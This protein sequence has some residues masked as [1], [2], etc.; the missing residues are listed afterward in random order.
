MLI[1]SRALLGIAGATVAPSTLSLVTNLFRDPRQRATAFGVWLGC[2]TLGA[3]I[4]PVV[5]GAMLAHFW[6]GSVFLLGVPAMVLLLVLGPVLLPEYRAPAA[7]RLDLISAALLLATILP[8]VYGLKELARHGWQP[9]PVAAIV[10]GGAFAVVFVRRQH[11]LADPLLDLRLFANPAFSTVLGSMLTFSML[12]GGTMVF[13]AQHFQ[14]VDELSALQAG[15]ALLPGMVAGLISVQLGPLLARWVRPAYLIGAGVAVSVSG[16]LVIVMSGRGSGPVPLMIGLAIASLGGG[17]LLSLGTDLVIGSAPAE[18]AGSASGLV[19]TGSELGYAL[20]IAITGSIATVVYHTRITDQ[21]P[22]DVP[23]AAAGAARESITGA[24]TA[25][26]SLPQDLGA[27]VLG[28]A[29]DAFSSGLQTV[30]AVTA[31]ALAVV[32][33]LLVT[34]LRR[35]RPL[36]RPEAAVPEPDRARE[37]VS[38]RP[39]G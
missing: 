19:Q 29:R 31:A 1:V 16:F 37:R 39:V 15:L 34:Q 33:V 8:V 30:A 6:W 17:P 7:G 28:A 25:A 26:A 21:I 20:G 11:T 9:W 23:A 36:D 32:A 10:A 18:K 4:G 2:F 14:L 12:S 5:G 35:M 27:A 3:I 22:P 38:S 24:G 13:V